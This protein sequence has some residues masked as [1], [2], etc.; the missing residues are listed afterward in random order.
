MDTEATR[1]LVTKFLE[2]RSSGDVEAIKGFLA[3]DVVWTLPKSATFGPFEGR[4]KVAKALGGGVQ[5]QLF[6]VSTM[7]REIRKMV[8]EGDTAMVQQRL[9]ANTKEGGLYD[10]EYCWVYTCRDGKI[11]QLTEYAD[12]LNAAKML[13][14]LKR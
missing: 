13:G 2:A 8:V 11:S 12:T 4:D 7:K 10:N 14:T 3:D 9:T 1:T 5:A 6:D